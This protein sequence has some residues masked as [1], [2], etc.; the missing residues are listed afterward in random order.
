MNKHTE[1]DNAS[2]EKINADDGVRWV[3]DP[4]SLDKLRITAG[5]NQAAEQ[6]V[7]IIIEALKTN[8]K[9]I[10]A[11]GGGIRHGK[12]RGCLLG[13]GSFEKSGYSNSGVV[14]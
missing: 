9:V 2:D 7:P 12:K 5:H 14:I 4:L 8:E 6:L 11:A 1:I 13:W 10:F 3:T